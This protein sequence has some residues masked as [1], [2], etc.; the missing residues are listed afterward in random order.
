MGIFRIRHKGTPHAPSLRRAAADE[1]T[2]VIH[3][4]LS[5]DVPV[6]GIDERPGVRAL[7]AGQRPRGPHPPWRETT[8]RVRLVRAPDDPDDPNRIAVL[9]ESGWTV[10][11]VDRTRAI[12]I[13]PAL[14]RFVR[15]LTAKRAF[16]RCALEVRCTAV[17]WAEWD[18]GGAADADDCPTEVGMVLLVDDRDLAIAPAVPEI[19]ARV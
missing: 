12:R 16:A 15:D 17:A 8:M 5:G 6:T 11:D 3:R 4:D 7:I 1:V 19:P 13:A 18:P 2:L 10:G 14:D 9:T